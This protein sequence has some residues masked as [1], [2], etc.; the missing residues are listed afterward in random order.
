MFVLLDEVSKAHHLLKFYL[1]MKANQGLDKLKVAVKVVFSL[2]MTSNGDSYKL[3]ISPKDPTNQ[4]SVQEAQEVLD[5]V[6]DVLQDL[7]WLGLVISVKKNFSRIYATHLLT[8][9]FNS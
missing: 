4:M 8:G 2:G 3:E 6:K 1:K 7:V 9:I 5:E